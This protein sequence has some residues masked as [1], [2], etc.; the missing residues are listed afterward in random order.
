M[1]LGNA[2]DISVLTLTLY[3][4]IDLESSYGSTNNNI[5]NYIFLTITSQITS[6]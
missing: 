6:S 1:Y 4:E 3:V 2:G 5:T